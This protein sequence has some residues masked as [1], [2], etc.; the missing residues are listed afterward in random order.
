VSRELRSDAELASALLSGDESVFSEFV[1][2]F[3]AR[4]ANYTFLMC[5]QREDAEE[6][7]QETLLKVF[8]SIDQ[9]HDPAKLKA[10]VFRIARNECFM[11]R[12]KSVFAPQHE[13]SLEDL[14]PL[15]QIADWNALPDDLV[16]NAELREM[17][18]RSIRDLPESYRSVV[19]LRDVEGLSTEETADILEISTDLVK[20]RLHRGRLALRQALGEKQHA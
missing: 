9:L 6:V 10:W 8:E 1:Q 13:L 20:T 17:L 14:T 4:L 18:T 3:H 16:L 12:R 19:L 7:A 2:V 11:K 15:R 5:G